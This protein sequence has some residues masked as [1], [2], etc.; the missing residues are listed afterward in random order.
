M[1]IEGK[2]V[3]E[4]KK[5]SRILDSDKKLQK[6]G[7][8]YN[9]FHEKPLTEDEIHLVAGRKDEFNELIDA[10]GERRNILITGARGIGK[11][12][13]LSYLIANAKKENITITYLGDPPLSE[14]RFFLNILL[15]MLNK[16]NNKI[17][18]NYDLEKVYGRIEKY[19]NNPAHYPSYEILEDII[20]YAEKYYKRVDFPIIV[21][22]DEFHKIMLAPGLTGFELIIKLNQTMFDEKFVFVCASLITETRNKYSSNPSKE[23]LMERFSVKLDLEPLT[24]KDT[25][26]LIEKRLKDARIKGFTPIF[27]FSDRTIQEIYEASKTPRNTTSICSALVKHSVSNKITPKIVKRVTTYLGLTPAQRLKKMLRPKARIVYDTLLEE[28]TPTSP[29]DLNKILGMPISTVCYYLKDLEGNGLIT[30]MGLGTHVKYF[31]DL[32]EDIITIAKGHLQTMDGSPVIKSGEDVFISGSGNEASN[33]KSKKV[34]V[35]IS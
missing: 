15:S 26:Q 2:T 33:T 13:V 35:K 18:K 12:T 27:S 24:L 9:P 23:S 16:K 25:T 6:I 28:N 10:I 29:S 1:N 5:R 7:L 4:D 3:G 20:H 8:K 22:I 30:H 34:K 14:R 19:K 32:Q 21:F 31:I 17:S 11:S